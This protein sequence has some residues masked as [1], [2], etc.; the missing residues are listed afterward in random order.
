[1]N[2]QTINNTIR[3]LALGAAV[4]LAFAACESPVEPPARARNPRSVDQLVLGMWVQDDGRGQAQYIHFVNDGTA[5]VWA[6]YESVSELDD[7]DFDRTWEIKDGAPFDV[8]I[9]G[10]GVLTYDPGRDVLWDNN[11]QSYRR[12]QL[13]SLD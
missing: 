12:T 7:L 2:Q 10:F 3:A 8:E 4:A 5:A 9:E 1:M 6:E 13:L 11:R